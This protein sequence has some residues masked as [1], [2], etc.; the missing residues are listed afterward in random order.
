MIYLAILRGRYEHLLTLELPAFLELYPE[1]N[2][3]KSFNERYELS[4]VKADEK[5]K[6]CKTLSESEVNLLFRC[7]NMM[8]VSVEM[9]NDKAFKCCELSVRLIE[10]ESGQG[11]KPGGDNGPRIL[12]RMHLHS[13][14]VKAKRKRPVLSPVN[15]NKRDRNGLTYLDILSG[16]IIQDQNEDKREKRSS[17]RPSKSKFEGSEKE[18]SPS[19]TK[20][21]SSKKKY[22]EKESRNKKSS[23]T[24]KDKKEIVLN[25]ASVVPD[26]QPIGNLEFLNQLAEVAG[27][28]HS[29]ESN[30]RSR[31]SGKKGQKS[32]SG[33]GS[34]SMS[35]PPLMSHMSV[36]KAMQ[37]MPMPMTMPM[38]MPMPMHGIAPLSAMQMQMHMP[39]IPLHMPPLPM[40]L[41][42][43][44]MP[45]MLN[46]PTMPNTV[47]MPDTQSMPPTSSKPSTATPTTTSEF[48]VPIQFA[49]AFDGLN[50][51]HQNQNQQNELS[52]IE[53]DAN[54]TGGAE[55]QELSQV[56]IESDISEYNDQFK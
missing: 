15:L 49:E 31:G 17:K 10:G 39:P 51:Y 30:T 45:N 24:K 44:N 18:G 34:I 2:Y 6:F 22:E 12:H 52:R 28:L 25:L 54:S 53:E 14:L 11:F 7:Y 4:Q 35:M 5:D 21:S 46:M 29:E 1:F 42:M 8:V 26:Q 41:S 50:N 38:T 27:A 47:N 32:N 16:A 19:S 3:S 37:G 23:S 43:P 55:S 20:K 56:S 33:S 40:H 48:F 13:K 9:T 36:A